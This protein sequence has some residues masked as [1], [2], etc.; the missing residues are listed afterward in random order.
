LARTWERA[1]LAPKNFPIIQ[2]SWVSFIFR[3]L[4]ALVAMATA[5]GVDEKANQIVNRGDTWMETPEGEALR[6]LVMTKG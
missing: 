3:Q 2:E 6:R 1:I 4:F 5:L